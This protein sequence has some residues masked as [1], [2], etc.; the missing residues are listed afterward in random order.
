MK[1]II[2]LFLILLFSTTKCAVAGDIG[3]PILNKKDAL[4]SSL[5]YTAKQDYENA[6][7]ALK[8]FVTNSLEAKFLSLELMNPDY[9]RGAVQNWSTNYEEEYREIIF[10]IENSKPDLFVYENVKDFMCSVL[11]SYIYEVVTNF[12]RTEGLKDLAHTEGLKDLTGV[13]ETFFSCLGRANAIYFSTYAPLLIWDIA[14]EVKVQDRLGLAKT[15]YET[16]I[17]LVVLLQGSL[18]VLNY[19]VGAI[20]GKYGNK[21]YSAFVQYQLDSKANSPVGMISLDEV[22][23]VYNDAKSS[24]IT[25]EADQKFLDDVYERLFQNLDFIEALDY[26]SVKTAQTRGNHSSSTQEPTT[27][28]ILGKVDTG[29]A[30]E[31]NFWGIVTDENT[32]EFYEVYL[33]QYPKGTFSPLAELLIQKFSNVE[34][35]TATVSIEK[36]NTIYKALIIANEEYDFWKNLR[37]P[38]QDQARISSILRNKYGVEVAEHTDLKR[39]DFLRV[40][41]DFFESARPNDNLIF[42]YA[43]HGERIDEAGFWVPVDAERNR[44]FDWINIQQVQ[45]YAKKSKAKNILFLIDSCF[46]GII[47]STNRG[48]SIVDLESSNRPSN[49]YVRVAISSGQSDQSSSDIGPFD[50]RYSPFARALYD[51]LDSFKSGFNSRDLFGEVMSIFPTSLEQQPNWGVIIEANHVVG[52]FEFL[53]K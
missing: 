14:T 18:T 1:N 48:L 4:I 40:T 9:R 53:L 25:L 52:D 49:E 44:D 26:F 35:S 46:S 38:I 8:P 42:Y 13:S 24:Q 3:V 2:S 36:N 51:S 16:A 31:M 19:E 5:S 7:F 21:T 50:K 37:T 30:A 10:A 34:N 28:K 27:S 43:G 12:N 15:M 6:L 41:H 45:R 29:L 23:A 47:N 32:K 11:Q 17:D 22:L 39:A 20:D 33:T